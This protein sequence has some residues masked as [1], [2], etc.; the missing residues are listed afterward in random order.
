MKGY[1]EAR[2]KD[3]DLIVFPECC[4]TGYPPRDIPR[5]DLVNFDLVKEN[6]KNEIP[7]NYNHSTYTENGIKDCSRCT[8]PHRAENYDKIMEKMGVVMELARKK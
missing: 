4:L 2:K 8:K 5:A 7:R 1:Y 6:F 3:V